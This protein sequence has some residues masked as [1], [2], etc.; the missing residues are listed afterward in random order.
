MSSKIFMASILPVKIA[1]EASAISWASPATHDFI[2][3]SLAL[4]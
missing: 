4:I 1:A 3:N 2:P